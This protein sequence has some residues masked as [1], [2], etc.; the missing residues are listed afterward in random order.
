MP[1]A[2]VADEMRLGKAISSVAV[3]M[4]SKLVT[5]KV[6][7]GLPLSTLWGNTL[8]EWVILA[9]NDFPSIVGDVRKWYPLQRLNS[10]SRGLLEF[11][12][13]PPHG[14]PALISAL[15]PIL[16]VTVPGVAETIKSVIYEMTHGT[17]FKLINIVHAEN[18]N[19]THE[20]LYTSTDAPENPWNV[21]IV[22]YETSTCGGKRASN[23]QLSNCSWSFEIFDE[24]HRC[25]TKNTVG[26]QI[27]MNV[28]I[29]FTLQVTTT[30]GFHS[31][32]DWCF[33]MMW[34]F[35]CAPEDPDDDTVMEKHRTEAL[36]S[37]GKSLMHPIR[38]KDEEAQQHAPNLM[39]QIANPWTIQRWSELKLANGKPL[40]RIP[41]ENAH[42]ID[43]E[44][45]EEVITHRKIM[46]KWYT[47]RGASGA[48]MVHGLR[49]ACFS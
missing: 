1:G 19:L 21:H 4:L 3:A 28:R 43:L 39:I 44:S 33:Q 42:L 46:V 35:A 41:Q 13:P 36:Y 37:A 47:S 32:H 5:E 48:W 34:W 14:H 23:G 11:Q 24:N 2:L 26:W 7:M 38:T 30:M 49:L 27:A 20:D 31:F 45:T 29:V 12:S 6:V 15:Q 16:M 17:D 22:S 25:K 8:E 18:V 40:A 10:V 9:H